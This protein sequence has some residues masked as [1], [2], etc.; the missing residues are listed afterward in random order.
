M[1]NATLYDNAAES[2]GVLSGRGIEEELFALQSVAPEE[3]SS[4]P[5]VFKESVL[6]SVN[7]M[8]DSRNAGSVMALLKGTDLGDQ[9]AVFAALES[10]PYRRNIFLKRGISMEFQARVRN[11]VKKAVGFQLATDVSMTSR[12]GLRR[13]R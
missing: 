13:I 10:L 12:F 6:S 5:R 4:L 3:I 7:D 1:I 2:L 11:L 9:G 8:F